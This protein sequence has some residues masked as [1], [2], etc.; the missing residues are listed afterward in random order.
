MAAF[1]SNPAVSLLA[2]CQAAAEARPMI[3]ALQTGTSGVCLETD[4]PAEVPPRSLYAVHYRMGLVNSEY[5]AS[6]AAVIT[7]RGT[8][9]CVLH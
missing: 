7:M 5:V 1:Q 8:S 9:A 2:T 4:D 6:V 3:E